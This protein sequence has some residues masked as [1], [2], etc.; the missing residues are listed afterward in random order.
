MALGGKRP[1][2]GRPKGTTKIA[3]TLQI[4]EFV[5]KV[6]EQ[7]KATGALTTPAALPTDPGKLD[8]PILP[9]H[10]DDP[11]DFLAAMMN[12]QKLHPDA[13]RDAAKALMPFVHVK[14]GEGGKKEAAAEASK[15]V[16]RGKFSASAA[17]K[18]VASRG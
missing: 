14:K 15:A 9:D 2:A 12:C 16:A 5:A 13:R 11:K 7:Q 18:L 4:G 8:D 1:G 3:K 17:P 6:F 10:Y